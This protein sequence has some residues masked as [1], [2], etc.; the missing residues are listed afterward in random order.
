[1]GTVYE[2][3]VIG[4]LDY[5]LRETAIRRRGGEKP[6]ANV[7]DAAAMSSNGSEFVASA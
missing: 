2:R 1:M 5:E 3:G 7:A 4:S 6:G